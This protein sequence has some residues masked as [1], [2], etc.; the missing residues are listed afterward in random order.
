MHRPRNILWYTSTTP[1][2][3][4]K[5][6]S[7]R[8]VVRRGNKASIYDTCWKD[9]SYGLNGPTWQMIFGASEIPFRGHLITKNA[10]D[11]LS[12]VLVPSLNAKSNGLHE[13]NRTSS[14]QKTPNC[15]AYS[16]TQTFDHI[17]EINLPDCKKQYFAISSTWAQ[18]DLH[19][20][21]Q[22]VRSRATFSQTRHNVATIMGL[23]AHRK[24]SQDRGCVGVPTR[25]RLH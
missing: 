13:Q 6:G 7:I 24:T 20:R 23:E 3:F 22:T 17:L 12:T 10:I 18:P 21:S 16:V 15:K 5:L 14:T 2:S 19:G 11:T 1:T 9:K 25:K 8:P 4:K